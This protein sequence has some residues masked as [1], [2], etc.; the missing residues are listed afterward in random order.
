MFKGKWGK[1][2]GREEA[3]GTSRGVE[4]KSEREGPRNLGLEDALHL[5]EGEAVTA[6]QMLQTGRSA[7]MSTEEHTD[8]VCPQ[9]CVH[10]CA[11]EHYRPRVCLSLHSQGR[12]PG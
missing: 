4:S 8:H 11:C 7:M 6:A 9:V 1:G 5:Q 12:F 10:T 2:L 3:E